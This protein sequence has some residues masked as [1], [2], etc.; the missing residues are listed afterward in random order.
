MTFS[1]FIPELRGRC[2][3]APP[4]LYYLAGL[5]CTDENGR[6]KAGVYEQAAKWGLAVCFPDTSAR[7]VEIE[8]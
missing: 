7:G 6:T 8:G 3:R 2:D 4:L 5:T 1:I